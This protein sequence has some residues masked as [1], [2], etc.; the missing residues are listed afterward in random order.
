MKL[1]NIDLSLSL[2]TFN[3]G[4]RTSECRFIW[5]SEV[6]QASVGVFQECL[7]SSPGQGAGLQEGLLLLL[8]L[9]DQLSDQGGPVLI[10]ARVPVHNMI[11]VGGCGENIAIIMTLTA[12]MRK[13][14]MT[15]YL[16]SQSS[17]RLYSRSRLSSTEHT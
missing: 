8:V 15:R 14:L 1:K 5:M 16:E 17:S 4:F 11:K 7:C 3:F 10:R 12:R 13:T 9:V 2:L 6:L